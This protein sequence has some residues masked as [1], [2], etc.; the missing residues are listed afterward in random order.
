[1]S[2][3]LGGVA[4]SDHLVLEGLENGARI[5]TSTRRTLGGGSV[6]QMIG[7]TGGRTLTLQAENHISLAE[8]EQVKGLEAA[9][10]AVTLVHPRGTFSVVITGTDFAT[11]HPLADTP[12]D[13]LYSGTITMIEV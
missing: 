5:A 9:A 2:V 7:L 8:I 10:Q 12:S 13:E 1:M 6:T 3:T 11:D 4:L